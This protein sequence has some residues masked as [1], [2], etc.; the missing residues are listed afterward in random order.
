MFKQ[1]LMFECYTLILQ[2]G[3]SRVTENI[4]HEKN[5]NLLKFD[6]FFKIV[7]SESKKKFIY[8]NYS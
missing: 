1:I 8:K 5:N 2:I 3:K 7:R 4:L 6:N